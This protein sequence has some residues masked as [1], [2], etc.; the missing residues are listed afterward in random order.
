MKEF[1]RI[2]ITNNVIVSNMRLQNGHAYYA[3]IRGKR[4]ISRFCLQWLH[5]T[6]LR[7]RKGRFIKRGKEYFN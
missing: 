5:E 2:G 4:T 1:T 7:P 6:L 3:T